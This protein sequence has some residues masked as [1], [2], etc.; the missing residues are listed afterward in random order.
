MNEVFAF[1]VWV[2]G[3]DC[4][5]TTVN[6]AT[7][8]KA[9]YKHWREVITEVAPDLPITVMRARK[10]GAPVSTAQFLRTA[11]YRGLPALRCGQRVRVG[12][13]RGVVVGSD[14]SANF[15]VLF[16]EDCPKYPGLTLSVHPSELQ[17]EP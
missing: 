17:L 2:A 14:A 4:P 1:D 8:G 11:E 6:A 5:P 10:V 15:R 13:G 12:S 3:C 7:A 9:K 16:D